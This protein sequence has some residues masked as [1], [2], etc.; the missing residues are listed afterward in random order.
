MTKSPELQMGL[1]TEGCCFP[2]R[3]RR[4]DGGEEALDLTALSGLWVTSISR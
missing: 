4:E 1:G 3:K 2:G